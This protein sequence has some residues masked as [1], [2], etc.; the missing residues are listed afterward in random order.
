MKDKDQDCAVGNYQMSFQLPNGGSASVSGYIHL[1]DTESELNARIDMHVKVM[2]RQQRRAELPV[3]KAQREQLAGHIK[4]MEEQFGV[5]SEKSSANRKLNSQD[6]SAYRALPTNIK[7]LKEKL[8]DGDVRI[9]DL[10]A[11]TV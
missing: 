2:Q 9:A 7:A 4:A 6:D 11:E 10:E 1:S 5:L 3:L 8:A